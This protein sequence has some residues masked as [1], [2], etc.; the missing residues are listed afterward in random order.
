MRLCSLGLVAA[1]ALTPSACGGEGGEDGG[2]DG[3][4]T[5]GGSAI[6]VDSETL[7]PGRV[8]LGTGTTSFVEIPESGGR[9]E[10]VAGPQGGW[11]VDVTA[12][13]YDFEIEGLLLS[14]EIRRDGAVVS[15]PRQF[16]LR[17]AIVVR[18]G[19][20]WLRAGDFVPFEIAMPSDVVGDTVTVQVLAEPTEGSAASDERTVLIVDEE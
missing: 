18:E 2:A 17:E 5:D 20:H 14:Y 4:S 10:L 9:L 11:H 12:R 7:A 19:D 6:D 13:L 1:L 8:E 16:A 3:G 15:M